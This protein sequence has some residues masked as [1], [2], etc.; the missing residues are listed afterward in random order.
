MRFI[1]NY[2]KFCLVGLIGMAVD[3]TFLWLFTS[4]WDM[5]LFLGKAMAAEMAVVNNFFWNE[6]W[7]FRTINKR[8]HWFRR[9]IRFNLVCMVGMGVSVGLLTFQ[10]Y[11]LGMNRFVSNTI[12][13]VLVSVWNYLM[14][15]WYGWGGKETNFGQPAR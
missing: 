13:I 12:A 11:E 8:D 5:G 3:M 9:F 14:S 10:V 2:I 1:I 4:C 15:R 6:H 7:T